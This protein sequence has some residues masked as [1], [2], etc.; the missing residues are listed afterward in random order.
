MILQSDQLRRKEDRIIH[1]VVNNLFSVSLISLMTV[2]VGTILDGLIISNYLSETAFAAFSLSAPLTNL[3]EM[4]GN[5]IA[6][7]CVVACGRLIGAGKSEEANRSFRSCLTL[8]LAAGGGIA[9]PLFFFPQITGFLVSGKNGSEFMPKMF[10][11]IRGM[12]LGIPA[13]MLTA[14]LNGIVQLDG[15]KKRVLTAAY[16]ICGTNLAGDLLV[17]TLAAGGFSAGAVVQTG[18]GVSTLIGVYTWIPGIVLVLSLGIMFVYNLDKLYPEVARTLRDRRE[19]GRNL[20][21]D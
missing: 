12:A 9:V 10:Q 11:Y 20:Y 18:R 14:Q 17:V 1:S 7:G 8:C 2:L 13:I 5:V 6:T 19:Q 16:V 15:G 3:I 4:I 21:Y